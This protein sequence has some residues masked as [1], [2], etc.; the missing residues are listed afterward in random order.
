MKIILMTPAQDPQG[1]DP[2]GLKLYFF[3]RDIPEDDFKTSLLDVI[4]AEGTGLSRSFPAEEQDEQGDEL[5]EPLNLAQ[6]LARYRKQDTMTR[7]LVMAG[8]IQADILPEEAPTIPG[9]DIAAVLE[10][11]RETSGDFY[12]FIPSPIINGGWWSQDV[13]DKGMGPAHC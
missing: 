9:W 13:T 1:N 8:R 2:G 6:V 7:E 4:R 11:A 10:P 3:S 12:D 5:E